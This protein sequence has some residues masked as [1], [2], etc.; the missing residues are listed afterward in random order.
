MQRQSDYNNP[1]S[2][3]CCRLHFR[4]ENQGTQTTQK[5]RAV[6]RLSP[7][8][9]CASYSC[10]RR[11]LMEDVCVPLC[12][13]AAAAAAAALVAVKQNV[14]TAFTRQMTTLR[15]RT[16]PKLAWGEKIWLLHCKKFSSCRND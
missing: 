16:E 6:L 15:M 3:C 4:R 12:V 8:R 7:R 10:R 2:R 14:H 5:P 1:H 9:L 11:S 13:T